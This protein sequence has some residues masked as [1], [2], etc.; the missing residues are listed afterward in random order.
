MGICQRSVIANSL[1]AFGLAPPLLPTVGAQETRIET[2]SMGSAEVHADR[3]WGAQTQRSL[4]NFRIGNERM[5]EALIRALGLVK[6]AAA[7]VNARRGELDP[8]LAA[9][10]IQ[11]ADEVIEGR[12]SEH[13]PGGGV[14]KRFIPIGAY[15]RSVKTSHLTP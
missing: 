8:E 12:L 11:A 13:F 7:T 5:P 3:Y 4:Q 15:R 10:I 2:D 9:A 14:P 1:L 6:K